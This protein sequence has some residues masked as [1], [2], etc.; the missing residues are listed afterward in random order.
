[1]EKDITELNPRYSKQ[2]NIVVSCLK[3]DATLREEYDVMKKQMIHHWHIYHKKFSL[4]VMQCR[5]PCKFWSMKIGVCQCPKTID[6]KMG[7]FHANS[8]ST[9]PFYSHRNSIQIYQF[10][11]QCRVQTTQ[12]SKPISNIIKISHIQM[13]ALPKLTDGMIHN[14]DPSTNHVANHGKSKNIQWSTY[15]YNPCQSICKSVC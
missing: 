3:I 10:P 4:N 9:N 6:S 2:P 8:F 12:K 7:R 1:M 5:S 14:L 15:E 11:V 13:W